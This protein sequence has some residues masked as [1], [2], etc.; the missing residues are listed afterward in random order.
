MDGSYASF[1]YFRLFLP[2]P[3]LA[4]AQAMERKAAVQAYCS[5]RY[6]AYDHFFDRS[7]FSLAFLG[8]AYINKLRGI[9]VH[10]GS[11]PSL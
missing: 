10:V 2:G 1:V 6:C 9:R 11:G 5:F 4:L 8:D 3:L 7:Q